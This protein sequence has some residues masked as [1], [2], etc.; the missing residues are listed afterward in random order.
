[1]CCFKALRLIQEK[2]KRKLYNISK[3]GVVSDIVFLP[4]EATF[5]MHFYGE[6]QSEVFVKVKHKPVGNL[7]TETLSDVQE[8]FQS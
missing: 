5:H 4:A 3:T 7:R 2:K 1:M 6:S 8:R